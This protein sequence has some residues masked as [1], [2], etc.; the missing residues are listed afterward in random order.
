MII[1]LPK[2]LTLVLGKTRVFKK[3][4]TPQHATR[5][6]LSWET[7]DSDIVGIAN[8]AGDIRVF[9]IKP[10]KAD[11]TLIIKQIYKYDKGQE[12]IV[13]EISKICKVTVKANLP[14][15]SMTFDAV[16]GNPLSTSNITSEELALV[17][18]VYSK[19]SSNVNPHWLGDL[20]S[21]FINTGSKYGINPVFLASFVPTEGSWDRNVNTMVRDQKNIYSWSGDS[22]G[23]NSPW[24]T[25]E[26]YEECID[27]WAYTMVD[28]Y[29]TP[30][31]GKA[32]SY[33]HFDAN[34][35]LLLSVWLK[36]YNPG[37]DGDIE[38][39]I[40]YSDPFFKAVKAKLG[41]VR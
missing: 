11:V 7:S 9:G 6:E 29:F 19:D 18:N 39:R 3:V 27:F 17:L 31:K 41:S 13:R 40:E 23:Y 36:T 26:S 37:S 33:G 14:V 12:I 15:V 24:K 38:K 25:F 32:K 28:D 4:I 2:E 21:T 8:K 35:N 22:K 1:A 16:W 34:G 30:N 5:F 20:A 10:G